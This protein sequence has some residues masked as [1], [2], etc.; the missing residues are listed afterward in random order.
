MDGS[1]SPGGFVHT[2]HFPR[3]KK[4]PP[5]RLL[6]LAE[7]VGFEPTLRHN[8]KPDFESGAFDHSATSPEM[9][10]PGLVAVHAGA[11]FASSLRLTPRYARGQPFGC[12]NSFPTN[13]PTTLP[14][15]QKPGAQIRHRSEGRRWVDGMGWVKPAI[16][17]W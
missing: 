10:A 13:S 15:L 17:D 9:S 12:P 7:R 2:T 5:G 11:L 4:R 6:F 3:N 8:R 1:R 16:A 14:P